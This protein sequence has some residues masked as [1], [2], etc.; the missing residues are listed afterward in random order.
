MKDLRG[1][2]VLITGA[3]RGMGRLHAYAFAREGSRVVLTDIDETELKKTAGEMREAGYDVSSYT[4]DISSR[5][6]CFKLA[7]KV[8]DEVGPVDVLVNNAAIATNERVLDTSESAYRRITDVN[9][10]GQIWMMQAFVP[11]MV[12]RGSGHVVNI[13]SMAGKVSVVNLAPYCATKFA[14]IGITDGIRQELKKSGVKF[15]IVNPGYISTG[16]FEGAKVPFITRWQD[17]QKVTD[18]LLEGVKRD[19]AEVF[20]PRFVSH[21]TAFIRGLGL[22]KL[23]D[24]GLAIFRADKSFAPM[25][26]DRGRPF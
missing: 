19:R 25:H 16:M 12:R 13:C 6:A 21:L 18:A 24:I 23:A 2:V 4:V 3:A 20:V 5:E 10:L 22:P 11:E 17:P 1:K 9:Y 15:T 26:K 7:E 14:L 8:E